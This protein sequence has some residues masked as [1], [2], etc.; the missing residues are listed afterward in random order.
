MPF[1]THV[2]ERE[3]EDMTSIHGMKKKSLDSRAFFAGS[4]Y[5]TIK[6]GF[7]TRFKPGLIPLIGD[8]NS[9]VSPFGN[10]QGDKGDIQL[11]PPIQTQSKKNGFLLYLK[12]LLRASA[13]RRRIARPI[14]Q[15]LKTTFGSYISQNYLFQI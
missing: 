3:N 11:Y 12:L 6:S 7:E 5:S 15:N 10:G 8:T 13:N 1:W 2:R 14:Q 4:T 9:L